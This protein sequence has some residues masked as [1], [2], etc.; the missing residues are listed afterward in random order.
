[1]KKKRNWIEDCLGK[2]FILKIIVGNDCVL[3]YKK[4][5]RWMTVKGKLN[6]I[7]WNW[8]KIS[9]DENKKIKSLKKWKNLLN[10]R[11]KKIIRLC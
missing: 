4:K 10:W 1:M 7:P 9:A 6:D 3:G 5:I 8:A 2:A 11:E